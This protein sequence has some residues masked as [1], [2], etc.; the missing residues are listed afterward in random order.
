MLLT[1]SAVQHSRNGG[2]CCFFIIVTTAITMTP[3]VCFHEPLI[4][5][6]VSKDSEQE[7]FYKQIF[8]GNT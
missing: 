8:F 7:E 3:R 5:R 4:P 6:K 2:S 1:V